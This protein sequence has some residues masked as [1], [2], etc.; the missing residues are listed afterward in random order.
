MCG[1]TRGGR[2][3]SVSLPPLLGGIRSLYVPLPP[4]DPPCKHP[5]VVHMWPPGGS[6]PQ[7][8]GWRIEGVLWEKRG[9][10][11]IRKLSFPRNLDKAADSKGHPGSSAHLGEARDAPGPPRHAAFPVLVSLGT[12]RLAWS[13]RSRPEKPSSQRTDCLA[14]GAQGRSPLGGLDAGPGPGPGS[15]CGR[16]GPAEPWWPVFPSETV[17]YCSFLVWLRYCGFTGERCYC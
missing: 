15:M 16:P 2:S 11:S 1:G 10:G 9:R 3:F 4:P 6:C 8:F 5:P 17:S 14:S 7:P 12:S 13:T